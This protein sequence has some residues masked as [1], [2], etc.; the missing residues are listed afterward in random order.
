M[1]NFLRRLLSFALPRVK[2]FRGLDEHNV[3]HSGNLNIGLKEQY[4]FP[5]TNMETSKVSFGIQV[6]IVPKEKDRDS[7][8]DLYRSIG[9]PFKHKK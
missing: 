5:E 6:T 8:V 3:D 7:A 9:V 2:D 1:E 4:V